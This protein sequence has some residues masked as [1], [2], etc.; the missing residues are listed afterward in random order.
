[1][2]IGL[3]GLGKMGGNMARRLR[4]GG[5]EVVG[6]DRDPAVA[7]ALAPSAAW[8]RRIRPGSWSRCSQSPAWCG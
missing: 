8:W 4:R 5:V 2:R 3:I 1:M 7:A 6:F